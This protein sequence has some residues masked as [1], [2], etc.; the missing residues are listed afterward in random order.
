MLRGFFESLYWKL[1]AVFLLL[2]TSVGGAY[3]VLTFSSS[4]YRQEPKGSSD[5]DRSHCGFGLLSSVCAST[6]LS[7]S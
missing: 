4:D 5:S 6:S 3:I 2:L 7:V 1:S